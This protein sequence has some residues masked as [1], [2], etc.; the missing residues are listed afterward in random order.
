MNK[1]ADNDALQSSSI[2]SIASGGTTVCVKLNDSAGDSIATT[3]TLDRLFLTAPLCPDLDGDGYPSTCTACNNPHCPALD[4]NDNDVLVNPD[5]PEGPYGNS[6][7]SDNKDNNC[8][9]LSDA[10]EPACW[11]ITLASGESNPGSGDIGTIT[12]GAT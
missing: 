3:I 2:G 7:C 10:S 12:S 11:P 5:A 1:T 6:T 8:N 4:C 9:G